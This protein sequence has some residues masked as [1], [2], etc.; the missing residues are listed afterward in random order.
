MPMDVR[1]MQFQRLIDV[2]G[3]HVA[4]VAPVA[5]KYVAVHHLLHLTALFVSCPSPVRLY[6]KQPSRAN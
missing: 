5:D 2:H 1:E 4:A 6:Q 3:G